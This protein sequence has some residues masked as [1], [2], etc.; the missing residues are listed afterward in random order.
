MNDCATLEQQVT[1]QC[2]PEAKRLGTLPKHFGQHML[3]VEGRIYDFMFQFCRD[4]NG[5]IWEFHELSNGGFYM[6]PPE[7]SYAL[8][9]HGN[10]FRGTLSADAAGITVCLFAFSHLSF[11]YE[12]AA[13]LF[14]RYFHRLREY[15]A[16]HPE[17]RLIFS[18]ID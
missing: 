8:Y 12:H 3:T 7:R 5:G 4:Y 18:A 11:E 10:W 6:T 1:A 16:N 15:A 17:A 2:V 9:V 13:D 14:G